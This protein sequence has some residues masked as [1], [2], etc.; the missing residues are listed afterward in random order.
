MFNVRMFNVQCRETPH[1]NGQAAPA[2]KP[3]AELEHEI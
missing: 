1:S 3:L 2:G